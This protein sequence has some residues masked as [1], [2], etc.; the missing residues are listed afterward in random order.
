M[1]MDRGQRGNRTRTP[2]TWM[3]VPVSQPGLDELRERVVQHPLACRGRHRQQF[4]A[5]L[6][7]DGGPEVAHLAVGP[8]PT[9][10]MEKLM[11]R[12][13]NSG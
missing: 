13:S 11:P 1:R 8:V 4:I 6:A 12:R 10:C 7:A 5:K 9:T 3:A 2:S